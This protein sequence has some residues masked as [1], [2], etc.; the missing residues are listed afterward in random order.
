MKRERAIFALI[1]KIRDH[2]ILDLTANLDI[3]LKGNSS[4]LV[5]FVNENS[6]FKI[7]V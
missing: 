7:K 2:N 3:L 5:I 1:L 6:V 4:T